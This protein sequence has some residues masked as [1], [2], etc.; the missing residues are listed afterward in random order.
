MGF[1]DIFRSR[2]SSCSSKSSQDCGDCYYNDCNPCTQEEPTCPTTTQTCSKP[3]QPKCPPTDNCGKIEILKVGNCK[4]CGPA[5]TIKIA[6]TTS[7]PRFQVV[8]KKQTC[9]KTVCEPK[10][11]KSKKVVK[12]PKEIKCYRTKWVE[13]Q[14]PTT[15]KVWKCENVNDTK[16]IKR[17]VKEPYCKTVMVDKEI[18]GYKMKTICKKVPYQVEIQQCQPCPQP[19]EIPCEP[20][21]QTCEIPCEIPTTCEQNTCEE[22]QTCN[23]DCENPCDDNCGKPDLGD[24]ISYV[25]NKLKI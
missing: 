14:K 24:K 4:P 7:Q 6:T 13:C 12:V 8:Q 1:R 19:C 15:K 16:K 25:F 22:E 20:I 3:C 17:V 21:Q 11:V 23:I 2:S 9:Y 5:K 18:C 10:Q